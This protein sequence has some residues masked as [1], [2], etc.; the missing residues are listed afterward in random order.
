M[1]RNLFRPILTARRLALVAASFA[2]LGAVVPTASAADHDGWG[3]GR[4]YHGPAVVVRAQIGVPVI[5]PPPV[6]IARPMIVDEVPAGL[7]M[8]AYQSRDRVIVVING[9]NRAGGFTTALSAAGDSFILH[10]SAPIDGCREGASAFSISGS[11][12]SPR[13]LHQVCVR[14]GDRAFEVPVTC[15]QALS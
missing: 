4:H 8:T 2:V 3:W 14:I 11:I 6:V 9:T 10:N 15:V 5:V 13:E 7:Q 12:C 1:F